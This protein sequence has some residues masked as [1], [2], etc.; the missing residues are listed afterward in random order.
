MTTHDHCAKISLTLGYP[1]N[2]TE[3]AISIISNDQGMQ[4]ACT[5]M[6]QKGKRT[7]PLKNTQI[8]QNKQ[9]QIDA[10]GRF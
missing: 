8:Y 9:T 2:R 6:Y 5:W 3:R 4:K 1:K 10:R 7:Q